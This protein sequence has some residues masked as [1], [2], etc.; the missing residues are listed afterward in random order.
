MY[1]VEHLYIII[2][3]VITVIIAIN[4]VEFVMYVT[5]EVEGMSHAALFS[6]QTQ[7]N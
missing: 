1:P 6:G 7:S 5:T 4:Y 2:F 3:V